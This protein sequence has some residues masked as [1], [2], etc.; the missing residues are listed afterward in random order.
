MTEGNINI[1]QNLDFHF[2]K[3]ELDKAISQ[4]QGNR[5]FKEEIDWSYETL[6]K[7][8]QP[9]AVTGLFPVKKKDEEHVV[10]QGHTEELAQVVLTT[11]FKT[12]LLDPAELVFVSIV[13]L[14]PD[15]D[16]LRKEVQGKG[17]TLRS[18]VLDNAG[19]LALH[20]L[21]KSLNVLAE[22]EAKKRGWGLGYR[23]SPGSL[24]GWS[25]KDQRAMC[26]LLPIESIGIKLTNSS[27]L[28]P[29]KSVA[30]LVGMGPGFSSSRVKSACKW[31]EH[32]D[33]CIS[34]QPD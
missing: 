22:K 14:G 31:C 29:L 12:D 25:I 13:T 23:M 21:G 32:K 18:Y 16:N 5:R 2:D 1:L 15:L 26:S 8:V 33:T 24:S 28:T 10:V 34:M 9:K 6:N 4:S 30:G 20:H 7:V 17:R 3:A 11:G 27:M 19:V